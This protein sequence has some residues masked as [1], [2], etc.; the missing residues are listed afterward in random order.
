MGEAELDL[1]P[2]YLLLW[3]PASNLKCQKL[4]EEAAIIV[5]ADQRSVTFQ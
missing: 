5:L 4:M 1:S 3:M 2:V